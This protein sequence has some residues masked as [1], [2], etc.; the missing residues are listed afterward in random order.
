MK[1]TGLAVGALGLLVSVGA[2]SARAPIDQ[3]A[4]FDNSES[5]ITDLKTGLRW[6]RSTD[7]VTRTVAQAAAYC[8]ARGGRLPTYKELLSIVDESCLPVFV[9]GK[10]VT[11]CI[12]ADAF[13]ERPTGSFWT[14]TPASS[15]PRANYAVAFGSGLAATFSIEDVGLR[16]RCVK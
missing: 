2:A 3:Y 11:S 6:Q 10:L 14:S 15:S 9:D 12:D 7:A 8:Q 1:R 4:Q 13:P 16:V 5:E